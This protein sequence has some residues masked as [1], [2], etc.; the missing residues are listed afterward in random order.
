MIKLFNI[1]KEALEIDPAQ[2]PNPTSKTAGFLTKGFRDGEVDD[3]KINMHHVSISADKLKPTQTDLYL[4]KAI[5]MATRHFAGGELNAII[6]RDGYI[7]DGHHRW[8]STILTNPAM[9]LGGYQVD[10]KIDDLIPE[11]G[12]AHV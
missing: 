11:I 3:D 4:A 8:A 10:L 1:L 12:R 9:K 6:S 7:L 5:E 2:F